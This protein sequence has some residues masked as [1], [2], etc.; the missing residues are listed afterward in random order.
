MI[1]FVLGSFLAILLILFCCAFFIQAAKPLLLFLTK[2]A[3]LCFALFAI[4]TLFA[5]VIE[6]ADPPTYEESTETASDGSVLVKL[7]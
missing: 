6:K 5:L 3:F 1:V 4:L 2:G 7:D